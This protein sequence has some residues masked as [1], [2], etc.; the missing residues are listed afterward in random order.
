M[1]KLIPYGL[2]VIAGTYYYLLSAKIFT[3]VYLTI[4]AGE[5]LSLLRWWYVPHRFGKPLIVLLCRGV[6]QLP[7]DDV[8]KL[9]LAMAIIPAAITVMFTY[10]IALRLTKSVGLSV[11][12]ALVLMG[13]VMFTSQSGVV[14]QYT[15]TTM[16]LTMGFWFYVRGNKV[17]TLACL[18]LMTAT[19]ITGVFIMCIWV[20]VHWREKRE[21][22]KASWAF[23]LTGILPYGLIFLMMANPDIP[24]LIAGGLT[25]TA[26][27]GY[28][29]SGES[30]AAVLSIYDAP[31]RVAQ[32]VRLMLVSFGAAIVPFFVGIKTMGRREKVVLG[33]IGFI[34]WFWVTALH[35][36][37]WK[38]A[39]FFAPLVAVYAAVGLSKMVKWHTVVVVIGALALISLNAVYFNAN[40][41]AHEDPRATDYYEAL[42]EL[43]DGAAVVKHRGGAYAFTLHY[44]LSEG[45]DIVPL[46]QFDPFRKFDRRYYDSLGWLEQAYGVE[47][48]DLFDIIEYS[49]NQGW[50][51]YYGTPITRRWSKMVE[52]ETGEALSRVT[53]VNREPV[54][55]K[56]EE[57]PE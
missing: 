53:G 52:V 49:L 15:F 8:F 32:I 54:F 50:D 3:W 13:A 47:G 27:Y 46:P 2:F 57:E 38:Y 1:R 35:P 22:L 21:W 14:E 45:K 24:R 31:E 43:P 44:V 11:V 55:G 51:V 5:W 29:L 18:G 56:S 25:W 6:G 28:F 17:G 10:L 39:C 30:A 16:F 4:D 42:W 26:V 34:V 33:T 40:T 20:L 36:G 48:D 9:T 37:V 41:L 12:A 7:G 19:H 23:A